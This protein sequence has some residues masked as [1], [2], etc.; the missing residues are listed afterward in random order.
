LHT[1]WYGDK[2]AWV[3]AGG[4]MTN[5][6]QYYSNQTPWTSSSLR[7]AEA[8]HNYIE[9]ARAAAAEAA[10]TTYTKVPYLDPS[11]SAYGTNPAYAVAGSPSYGPATPNI[12]Q[13]NLPA[14][15][16]SSTLTGATS[17]APSVFSFLI[18]NSKGTRALNLEISALEADMKGRVISSPRILTADQ[19]PAVIEQGYEI[20]YQEASSSG[21]T[22]ISYKKAV[23]SLEVTPHI[24]P[25]G[26][27]SMR[28][29]VK[30][31]TPELLAGAAGVSINTKKVD[32]SVLVENG[33]TVI[34]GGIYQMS[35]KNQTDKVPLLGDLPVLGNF[36]KSD[37]KNIEK[38]ELL[39]F[40]T[41][42]IVSESLTVSN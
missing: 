31:D 14:A 30:K 38:V 40:I 37:S 13:V 33:G 9:D 21:A 4:D 7:G 8:Y 26:R 39:V 6:G 32:T 25:D 20:P 36:F 11:Y 42:R 34:I 23:M 28:L 12:N 35:S 41:P 16:A 22:S 1:K 19:Q 18:S 17:Q 29:L 5:T 3:G 24:T 2:G 15:A 27:I 10:G